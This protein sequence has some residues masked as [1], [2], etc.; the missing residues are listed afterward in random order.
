MAC[1]PQ[2]H[3]TISSFVFIVKKCSRYGYLMLLRAR[4]AI[5]RLMRTVIDFREWRSIK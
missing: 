5:E 4:A 1:K 2:K 3:A